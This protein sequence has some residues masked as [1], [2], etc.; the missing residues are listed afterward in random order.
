MQ[1]KKK[2]VKRKYKKIFNFLNLAYGATNMSAKYTMKKYITE[3]IEW[4]MT[5]NYIK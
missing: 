2:K 3:I 1:S 4:A 5:N